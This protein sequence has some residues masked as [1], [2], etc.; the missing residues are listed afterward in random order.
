MNLSLSRSDDAPPDWPD[1]DV[2]RTLENI[3]RSL[4]PAEATVSVVVVDDAFIQDLNARFRGKDRP[5]D[6]IT[7]SY[8]DDEAQEHDDLAGEVYISYDTVTRDAA[9]AGVD[10]AH[11][12]LRMGVHGLLH[13]LGYEHEA[14]ADADVMEGKERD[15]L[16]QHLGRENAEAL[17]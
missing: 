16:T 10:D 5:T 9:G 11:L 3:C 14:D 1:Q 13:V 4:E 7:F 2:A 15:I 17:F 12:F 6:V 8:L